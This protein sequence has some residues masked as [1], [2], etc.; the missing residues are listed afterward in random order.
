VLKSHQLVSEVLVHV[1]PEDDLEHDSNAMRMPGRDALLAHLAP[2]SAELG[3]V[4]R[5]VFHYI[6]G[7][8][9]AELYLAHDLFKT[10]AAL[11]KAQTK[12]D[13]Q[14]IDHAYFSAVTLYCTA[15][16]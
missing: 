11:R 14:L 5:V 16:N 12:L 6:A 2:L 15:V 3:P 1:D 7:K 13:K 4:Q 10:S 9:E 8:I